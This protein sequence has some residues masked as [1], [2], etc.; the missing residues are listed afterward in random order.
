MTHRLMYYTAFWEAHHAPGNFGVLDQTWRVL[1]QTWH[2]SL[3]T[4][5]AL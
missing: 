2:D 1:D 4:H 5:M 3:T